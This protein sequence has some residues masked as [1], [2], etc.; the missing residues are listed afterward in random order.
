[1]KPQ[2]Q[3]GKSFNTAGILKNH[4]LAHNGEKNFKCSNCDE[5]FKM[6]GNLKRHM[7]NKHKQTLV[8]ETL[9]DIT[10]VEC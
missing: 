10:F 7:M 2:S 6:K 3:C 9:E 1:M 8:E 4:L 5:R